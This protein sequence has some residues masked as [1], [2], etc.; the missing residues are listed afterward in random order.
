MNFTRRLRSSIPKYLQ[1]D[2]C[3][4]FAMLRPRLLGSLMHRPTAPS[5]RSLLPGALS[6]TMPEGNG[7]LALS[8]RAWADVKLVF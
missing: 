4:S 8:A 3:G 7:V 5:L 2:H 1:I 6:T